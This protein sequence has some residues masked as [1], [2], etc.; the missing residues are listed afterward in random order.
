MAQI[1]WVFTICHVQV[2]HCIIAH[3][4]LLLSHGDLKT[5]SELSNGKW[6][7][8]GKPGISLWLAVSSPRFMPMWHLNASLYIW[9]SFC[10]Y[11]LVLD[12]NLLV[13]VSCIPPYSVTISRSGIE[14][15][16]SIFLAFSKC[17]AWKRGKINTCGINKYMATIALMETGREKET[18]ESRPQSNQKAHSARALMGEISAR[19][20]RQMGGGV[21][22]ASLRAPFPGS[23]EGCVC[24]VLSPSSKRTFVPR[25][26]GAVPAAG[27]GLSTGRE[28]AGGA[29]MC[30]WDKML[31]VCSLH[32]SDSSWDKVASHHSVTIKNQLLSLS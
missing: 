30:A 28:A 1:Y 11:I 31:Q 32:G 8:R 27:G 2:L 17:L 16:K 22:A 6:A 18:E 14:V 20:G 7:A 24:P 15:F 21:G 26:T 13:G 3:N 10:C 23:L 25:R 19:Q 4:P 29:L 9:F 5:L 12:H